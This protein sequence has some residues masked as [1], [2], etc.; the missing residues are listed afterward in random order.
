[1]C[2]WPLVTLLRSVG[3]GSFIVSWRTPAE[4]YRSSDREG[5]PAWTGP[6]AGEVI[7]ERRRDEGR[8]QGSYWADL[9]CRRMTDLGF[10]RG[11]SIHNGPGL[12]RATPYRP[13]PPET[14]KNA[15]VQV[16]TTG[17][18]EKRER[19]RE[20]PPSSPCR[21]PVGTFGTSQWE[22]GGGSAAAAIRPKVVHV[23]RTCRVPD[24]AASGGTGM[25]GISPVHAGPCGMGCHLNRLRSWDSLISADD[26]YLKLP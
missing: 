22:E 21:R 9:R 16:R 17:T 25:Q 19:E 12:V 14:P 10:E 13:N 7:A 1:M 2:Q 26:L 15:A 3:V 5:G 18:T 24:D 20:P 8:R 4:Y 11:K 6:Q 23:G